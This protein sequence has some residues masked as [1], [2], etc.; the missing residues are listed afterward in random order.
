MFDLTSRITAENLVASGYKVGNSDSVPVSFLPKLF[1]IHLGMKT[2]KFS[3]KSLSSVMTHHFPKRY[4]SPYRKLD[5]L[6]GHSKMKKVANS[7]T[8]TVN[9]TRTPDA[10]FSPTLPKKPPS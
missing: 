5:L 9:M 3:K 1:P 10:P 7:S 6:H 2:T 4:E 8:D